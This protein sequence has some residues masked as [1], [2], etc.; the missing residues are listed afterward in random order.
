[1]SHVPERPREFV[2]KNCHLM[3]AGT[4]VRSD[5][6]EHHYDPPTEC[7]ACGSASFVELDAYPHTQ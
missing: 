6:G 3:Y 1:M 2:C 7:A 5:G 4:V